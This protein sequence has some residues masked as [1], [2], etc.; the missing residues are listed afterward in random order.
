MD[1]RYIC[2]G[3][4]L[5]VC[6]ILSLLQLQWLMTVTPFPVSMVELVIPLAQAID[7]LVQPNTM[8][9]TVRVVTVGRAPVEIGGY[10]FHA[11]T[12]SSA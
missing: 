4:L 5:L 11:Q 12:T 9:T 6:N 2:L 3:I 7:A 1:D 10:V 8:E